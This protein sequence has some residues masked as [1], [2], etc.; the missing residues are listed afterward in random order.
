V[1][2]L[3]TGGRL[4]NRLPLGERSGAATRKGGKPPITTMLPSSVFP[5]SG[6]SGHLPPWGRLSRHSFRCGEG[7][8]Y[9]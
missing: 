8:F 2:D 3:W 1:G 9:R 7:L 4:F 6:P 5:P